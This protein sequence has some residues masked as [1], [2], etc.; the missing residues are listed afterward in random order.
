MLLDDDLAASLPMEPKGRA[1]YRGIEQELKIIA[2]P[3]VPDDIWEHPI[4]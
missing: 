4:G 1:V 3:F 2:T